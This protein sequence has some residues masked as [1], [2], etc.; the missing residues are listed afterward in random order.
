MN[1]TEPKMNQTESKTT[2][3]EPKKRRRFGKRLFSRRHDQKTSSTL[4]ITDFLEGARSK[5]KSGPHGQAIEKLR[6]KL[7][8]VEEHAN[9]DVLSRRWKKAEDLSSHRRNPRSIE[10]L[11]KTSTDKAPL[12]SFL[13]F[14]YE[15]DE[16]REYSSSFGIDSNSLFEIE[17]FQVFDTFA[18]GRSTITHKLAFDQDGQFLFAKVSP[19]TCATYLPGKK[20]SK[21]LKKILDLV[22]KHKPLVLRGKKRQGHF[23]AY[24]SHGFRR[25]PKAKDLTEYAFKKGTCHK[26]IEKVEKALNEF[27]YNIEKCSRVIDSSMI[28]SQQFSLL[29]EEIELPTCSR[30]SESDFVKPSRMFH[31]GLSIGLDYWSQ[32]HT[33]EDCY[34][35]TLTVCSG[36]A[37]V[38]DYDEVVQNF[39][40][41]EYNQR[42]P[43]QNGEIL[44]FNSKI[45]HSS[46]NARRRGT[47]IM[48][49]H[50]STRTVRS[51]AACR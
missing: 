5:D 34:L 3:P 24:P 38:T 25:D 49:A 39:A 29:Q 47:Y 8:S 15:D 27:C 18:Q 17:H 10:Y 42:V 28:E 46:T 16:S 37:N 9:Y 12:G 51:R 32:V 21:F 48:S 7:P 4:K 1:R 30:Q 31:T 22:V 14:D 19:R 13:Y 50:N 45:E 36:E 41:P 26:V 2:E 23:K 35:T 43:M 40:F 44:L 33:D 20:Y 6:R 11:K